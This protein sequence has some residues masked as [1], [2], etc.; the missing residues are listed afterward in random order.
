[1]LPCPF[2]FPINDYA[3][4]SSLVVWSLY[5]VKVTY[6][7]PLTAKIKRGKDFFLESI[8]VWVVIGHVDS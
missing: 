8:L 3:V 1:M 4:S 7:N 5:H 6:N 2:F